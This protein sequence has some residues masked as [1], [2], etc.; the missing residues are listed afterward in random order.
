MYS[1]S[2]FE[3]R[4]VILFHV[5]VETTESVVGVPQD[6]ATPWIGYSQFGRVVVYR[7]LTLC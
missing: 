2:T 6:G 4:K 5:L 7:Y 3:G 1:Q